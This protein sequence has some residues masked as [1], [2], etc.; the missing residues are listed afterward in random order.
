[1]KDAQQ[2]DDAFA[3][4]SRASG[5]DDAVVG[6]RGSSVT[7]VSATRGP[8]S[9]PADY[10]FFIVSDKLYQQGL[11]AGARSSGGALR[12][13][14]TMKNFPELHAVEKALTAELGLKTTVR[15]YST[16][17]FSAIKTGAEILGR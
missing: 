7:G 4:F 14:A 5:V 15:I 10:D 2:L 13:S 8:V 11:S 9:T 16:E 1:M 3:R 12:V 6:I 17:G